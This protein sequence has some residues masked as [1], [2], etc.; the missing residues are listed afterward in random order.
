MPKWVNSTSPHFHQVKLVQSGDETA[1]AAAKELVKEYVR[2]LNIDLSFQGIDRELDEFPADYVP[3]RGALF[4]A[5]A[6]KKLAGVV[7]LR[8][9]STKTCEMKRMYVREEFR[10]RGIGRNLAELLIDE[11]SRR[12]YSRMRL[13]TLSTMKEAIGLYCSLGFREIAPYRFNP[14]RGA[15]Y[16]E[17]QIGPKRGRAAKF[18]E[19]SRDRRYAPDLGQP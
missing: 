14:I 11:A 1:V 15:T 12:G 7:A 6:G 17:L 19:V 2:S 3:P 13:D 8:M 18:A 5:L 10:G 16:M 9:V 4:V